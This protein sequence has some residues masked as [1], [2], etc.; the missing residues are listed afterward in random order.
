MHIKAAAGKTMLLVLHGTGANGNIRQDIGDIAPVFGIEHFVGG[1]E[2]A[3]LHGT[4]LHFSHS[5]EPG[6][7]D[8]E[9]KDVFTGKSNKFLVIVGPCSADNEDSVCAYVNRLAKVNE[10]VKTDTIPFL[11]LLVYHNR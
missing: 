4:N 5:D 10:K 6:K 2:P 1:C 9:I 3:L 7:R 11:N 8:A